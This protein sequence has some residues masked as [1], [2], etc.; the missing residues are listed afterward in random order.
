GLPVVSIPIRELAC[1]PDLFALAENAHDFADC[2]VRLHESR[3][4]EASLR[5]RAEQASRHTYESAFA[6]V[7]SRLLETR[8]VRA[9]HHDRLN[10]LVLCDVDAMG[11]PKVLQQLQAFQRFSLHQV[12]FFSVSRNAPLR[13][14]LALFDAV[15]VQEALLGRSWLLFRSE[16]EANPGFK[17][18]L[19][20]PGMESGNPTPEWCKE[21]GLQQCPVV[22]DKS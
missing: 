13:F 20:M 5:F 12:L 8:K 16:M 17:A 2:M 3:W 18:L 21:I 11:Q 10:V 19:P 7:V 9:P 22:F 1:S 15:V 6:D 14:D 4:Q